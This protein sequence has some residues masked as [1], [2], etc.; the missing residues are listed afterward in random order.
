MLVLGSST[1]GVLGRVA[2]GSVADRLLHSS[3]RAGRARPTRVPLP[4]R[5]QGAPGDGRLRCDRGLRRARHRCRGGRR[6]GA[7]ARCASRRFAVRP[8]T[9]LTAGIGSRAEDAVRTSG[10]R[11]PSTPSAPSWR[12]SNGCRAAR[13]RSSRWSAT[14]PTGRG[15]SRTS[16]GRTGTCW[17]SGRARRD[18]SSACSSAL[19]H[20]GSSGTRRCR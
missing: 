13:P 18:R 17:P 14:A 16:G 2:F 5:Q 3:P 9:P 10:R 12:T 6:A 15:R 20:R 7:C 4:A 1:A 11:T 8:R 19:A